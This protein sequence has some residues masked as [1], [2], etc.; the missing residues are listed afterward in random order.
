MN[1]RP[2]TEDVLDRADEMEVASVQMPV[3]DATD[4]I[5]GKLLSFDAHN[6]NFGNALSTVRALRE[7][8][9]WPA[10]RARVADSPYAVGFL[11]LAELLE[12]V[13]PPGKEES[14]W[15]IRCDPGESP[16]PSPI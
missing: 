13:P 8:V 15:P 3:L 12:I 6:C 9:D 1:G 4:L 7:Q 14:S 11:V 2:V 10:V 16:S 5:V